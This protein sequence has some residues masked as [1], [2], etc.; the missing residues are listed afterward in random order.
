MSTRGNDRRSRA[1]VLRRHGVRA[2]TAGAALTA[3]LLAVAGP[4]HA[5]T[6]VSVSGTVLQVVAGSASDDLVVFVSGNRLIVSNTADTVVGAAPCVG[7][8]ANQVACPS[9]G[10][11]VISAVTGKGDDR[12]RNRTALRSKVDLGP[13]T[14][15]FLGGLGSD[16]AFGGDGEDRLSGQAG[17]DTLVGDAGADSASGGDGTDRCDAEFETDCES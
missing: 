7:L 4:A 15:A 9:A 13:G 2:L 6:N 12:L 3:S 8:T 1:R 17:N 16:I 10:I 11:S 5:A 14:D